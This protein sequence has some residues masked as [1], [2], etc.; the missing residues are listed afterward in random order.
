MADFHHRGLA[1]SPFAH[2][3]TKLIYSPYRGSS[4]LL[5]D[6]SNKLLPSHPSVD[7]LIIYAKRYCSELFQ[8]V[9]CIE[10]ASIG[11]S[12]VHLAET[13]PLFDQK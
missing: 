9:I 12:Y 2:W 8:A 7:D 5:T 4:T 10:T 11:M 6:N 13:Q 3:R 1:G